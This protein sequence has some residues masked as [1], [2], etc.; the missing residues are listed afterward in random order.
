MRAI[1]ISDAEAKALVDRLELEKLMDE[2]RRELIY[3][4]GTYLNSRCGYTVNIRALNVLT[5]A[6]QELF[7]DIL[8]H[9][10]KR[11]RIGP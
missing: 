7:D 2:T 11:G 9:I 8:Q 5:S 3:A 6:E 1:I 10:V 4:F